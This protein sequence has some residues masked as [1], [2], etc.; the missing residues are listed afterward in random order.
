MR[1]VINRSR[2]NDHIKWF[3]VWICLGIIVWIFKFAREGFLV[4]IGFSLSWL[5]LGVAIIIVCAVLMHLFN[6][7]CRYFRGRS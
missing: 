2:K 5:F 7:V 1:K 6:W 4:F 3:G